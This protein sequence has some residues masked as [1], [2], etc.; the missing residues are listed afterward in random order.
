MA[1]KMKMVLLSFC[2]LWGCKS[3]VERDNKIKEFTLNDS[4]EQ[5]SRR[6]L[7]CQQITPKQV[8]DL[9]VKKEKRFGI[10]WKDRKDKNKNKKRIAYYNKIVLGVAISKL[11]TNI[12]L[13]EKIDHESENFFKLDQGLGRLIYQGAPHCYKAIQAC[14]SKNSCDYD[15]KFG[16]VAFGIEDFKD[17]Y[18]NEFEILMEKDQVSE[19]CVVDRATVLRS[20]NMNEVLDDLDQYCKA[21]EKTWFS[22]GLDMSLLGQEPAIKSYIVDTLIQNNILRDQKLLY[23]LCL[24]EE[25]QIDREDFQKKKDLAMGIGQTI[26]QWGLAALTPVP[27]SVLDEVA[28][29][30][31]VVGGS[32]ISM[33]QTLENLDDVDDISGCKNPLSSKRFQRRVQYITADVIGAFFSALFSVTVFS[34]STMFS[35]WVKNGTIKFAGNGTAQIT[36]KGAIKTLKGILEKVA[37]KGPLS[38]WIRVA[39]DKIELILPDPKLFL[40]NLEKV[41]DRISFGTITAKQKRKF[42]KMVSKSFLRMY[43]GA[44]KGDTDLVIELLDRK[45]AATKAFISKALVKKG[46]KNQT[47]HFLKTYL[48]SIDIGSAFFNARSKKNV[49]LFVKLAKKE[50]SPKEAASY[51]MKELIVTDQ[52]PVTVGKATLFMIKNANRVKNEV[53]PTPGEFASLDESQKQ[54]MLEQ[55]TEFQEEIKRLT[56]T[57][58]AKVKKIALEDLDN[59]E[60]G[61]FAK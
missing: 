45:T 25:K 6:S 27:G 1:L 29:T 53:G 51:A 18:K 21:D 5:I 54:K 47:K 14:T 36:N 59:S 41:V 50:M 39:E 60:E 10:T 44:R 52:M 23:G 49:E 7:F 43:K 58:I 2:V 12:A 61:L 32:V 38:N 31:V 34:T 42:L 3:T 20:L 19:S 13:A 26:T 46:T 37:K 22:P 35:V 24:S 55:I 9:V 48:K 8:E 33:L 30:S 57:E 40:A 16:H 11:M 4:E 56:K 15:S 17:T 28:L